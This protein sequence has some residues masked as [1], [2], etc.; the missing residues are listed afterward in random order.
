[1]IDDIKKDRAKHPNFE[2][3]ISHWRLKRKV[4]LL[5]NK[6]PEVVNAL[7]K[8]FKV[9]ALT[10]MDIGKCGNIES[11]E[12]WR[13][14]ELKRFNVTFS[15]NDKIPPLENNGFSFYKGIFLTGK[16]SKSKTIKYYFDHLKTETIVLVDDK[17]ENLEDVMDFCKDQSINFIGFLYTPT[18]RDIQTNERAALLQKEHLIKHA[19]WLEDDEAEEMLKSTSY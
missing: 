1:M 14:Q 3:I 5:D 11:I 15:D 13:Y 4:M 18:H 9:Y 10:K 16:N 17:R 12:K 6:W 7:K 8:R 2:E 19:T